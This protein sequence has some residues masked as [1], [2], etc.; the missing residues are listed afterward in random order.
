M[1]SGPET[2]LAV[3][4]SLGPGRVNAHVLADLRG[5]WRAGTVRGRLVKQGWGAW[6]GFPGMILDPTADAVPVDLLRSP[7]LPDHWARL[8]EF[9]GPGYRR[10]VVDVRTPD[11]VIRASIYVLAT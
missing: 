1:T 4:G 11:A 9:E 5:D 7:D 8:D 3:Y 10:V 6:L 2:C